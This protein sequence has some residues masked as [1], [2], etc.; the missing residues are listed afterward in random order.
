[1]KYLA[2]EMNISEDFLV[3]VTLKINW[4]LELERLN[5]ISK[6]PSKMPLTG[7]VKIPL[8]RHSIEIISAFEISPNWLESKKHQL[9]K[10][11]KNLLRFITSVTDKLVSL[12]IDFTIRIHSLFKDG[13]TIQ[14]TIMTLKSYF[15][16]FGLKQK[17]RNLTN[18]TRTNEFLVQS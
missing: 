15:C 12:F 2:F 10:N 5:I 18:F 6:M 17:I 9:C 14:I 3:F 11:A 16:T 8:V 7:T 13:D 4:I 1:M